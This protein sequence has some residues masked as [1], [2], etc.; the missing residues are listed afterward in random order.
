MADRKRSLV[1]IFV[2]LAVVIVGILL[3]VYRDTLFG[4][5][6][7]DPNESNT[8]V[9][10]G[11]TT[12]RWVP[13]KPPYALGMFG[14][15]IAKVQKAFG[16]SEIDQDGRLGTDTRDAIVAKNYSFP[17][18][19]PDYKKIVNPPSSGGG[20]NFANLKKALG[21]GSAVQNFGGGVLVSLDG[22]N[23]KYNINFYDNGRFI[24]KEL[25]SQAEIKRGTY[26]DGGKKLVVDG[27][28]TFTSSN[29]VYNVMRQLVDEYG[30]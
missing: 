7:P 21:S 10:P 8:P 12:T 23:K 24:L 26:V 14:P 16:F 25:V 20:S 5:N 1:W 15:N 22:K 28:K 29:S 3:Y 6:I 2:V 13:E 4:K 17:L 30:Q 27:G 9:P 18:S 11:S 19:E